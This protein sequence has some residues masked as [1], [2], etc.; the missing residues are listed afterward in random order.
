MNVDRAKLT[1]ILKFAG[2]ALIVLLMAA[3][4]VPVD[5][6]NPPVGE[7]IVAPA[8]VLTVLERACYDCHSN[9]TVWPVY[10]RVAPVSW[11]VARDVHEGR[12]AL[13]YST[14]GRYS[15][16][17]RS[18][19]L[20]ESWEEVAEGEMPMKPYVLL[21]PAARLTAEDEEVLRAW[22]LASGGRSDDGPASSD[23]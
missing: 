18:E 3:Q 19:L 15:A 5:R 9:E 2:L 1:R 20:E 8:E 22:S 14:W 21:H 17:E 10:S 23:D 11:L 13:N 16:E 12:E 7:E 6:T 4:F